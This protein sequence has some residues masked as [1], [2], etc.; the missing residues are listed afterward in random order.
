MA[1][2]TYT[3]ADSA[4]LECA[5]NPP[6]HDDPKAYSASAN[7]RIDTKYDLYPNANELL[8]L[9]KGNVSSKA[10]GVQYTCGAGDLVGDPVRI[11]GNLTVTKA[12]ATTAA[13][14]KVVG[15]IRHKGSLKSASVAG[16]TTCYLQNFLYVS[17][18]SGLTANNP[19][20]LTDAGGYSASAG[21]SAK[22]V[23]IAISAT[24]A[25]LCADEMLAQGA[26]AIAGGTADQILRVPSGGGAAGFGSINL[27]TAAAVGVTIL[28]GAN[29][30][31]NNAF[32]Q[33][34]GPA[35][36][37]KTFTLPNATCAIL[38]DNAAVTAAQGGTGNNNAVTS[39]LVFVAD[40]SKYVGVAMSGDVTIAT[41]G[42]T[43][44]GAGKVTTT[45]MGTADGGTLQ[46]GRNAV[47]NGN[48]LVAQRTDYVASVSATLG[49]GK[50]DRWRGY[51]TAGTSVSGTLTQDTAAPNGNSGYA[52]KWSAVT[53]TGTGG[54]VAFRHYVEAKDAI[55]FINRNAVLSAN[56]R[57]DVGSNVTFTMLITRANVA[58]TY[59]ATTGVFSMSPS[60][61][62]TGT[63]TPISSG[64][65]AMG[66]SIGNGFY[67]EIQAAVGTVAG[68]NVWL[69]EVQLELGSK[70]TPYEQRPYDQEFSLCERWYQ[71]YGG[72]VVNEPIG[73]GANFSTSQCQGVLPLRKTMRTTPTPT[74]S[75]PTNFAV[76]NAAGA[77]QAL[78][79]APTLTL[80]TKAC[81]WSAAVAATPLVAGNGNFLFITNT[82][83][84]LVLDAEF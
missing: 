61:V 10:R 43:A 7:K 21:T 62:V 35:T 51:M 38:T 55:R 26:A 70:E 45:M 72:A 12:L 63:S 23:G 25:L 37:L 80:S 52:I 6:A 5:F 48:G 44:I 79:G 31:T 15:F 18:L 47:I 30:G 84:K 11:S 49:Y 57:H 2:Q 65:Q 14:A 19:V 32:M 24:E 17:G 33:V 82:N 20:Y 71:V 41:G 27:A 54:V 64:V 40:G 39:G 78:T 3:P 8:A 56:V 73:I 53:T 42:A 59:G 74:W 34:T 81:F 36:S 76:V 77:N 1:I 60:A 50:C 4:A 29:G 68:K 67:I 58:D 46:S 66:A 69:T 22:I 13:N 9:I 75:N 83:A 16:A 28:A